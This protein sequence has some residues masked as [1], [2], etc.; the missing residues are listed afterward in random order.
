MSSYY[1]SLLIACPPMDRERAKASLFLFSYLSVTFNPRIG[2][3]TKQ[4][5]RV[6]SKS[7]VFLFLHC[8]KNTDEPKFEL[9][10]DKLLKESVDVF[11]N[12]MVASSRVPWLLCGLMNQHSIL[13]QRQVVYRSTHSNVQSSIDVG[14]VQ[15]SDRQ[16]RTL[17][18]DRHHKVTVCTAS[19]ASQ[20]EA[21]TR[22]PGQYLVGRLGDQAR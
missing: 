4:S 15:C 2:A 20:T 16:R 10:I 19:P 14:A 8:R 21:V 18:L 11:F 22:T 7:K 13:F 5:V 12:T 17:S 9:L 3:K 1:T 6:F